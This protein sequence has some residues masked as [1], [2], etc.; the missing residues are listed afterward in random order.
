MIIKIIKGAELSQCLEY[1]AGKG[2]DA[3]FVGGNMASTSIQ[4]IA[5]EFGLVYALAPRLKKNVRHIVVALDEHDPH[6]SLKNALEL[7]KRV[8][9]G[10]KFEQSPWM[11]FQH[12]DGHV[13]HLHIVTTPV[14]YDGGRVPEWN[15]FS[16]AMKLQQQ[17]E[18][19]A[20]LTL[21]PQLRRDDPRLPKLGVYG[22]G[23][24]SDG[25]PKLPPTGK[26]K[27]SHLT[28][29]ERIRIPATRS[30]TPQATTRSLGQNHPGKRDLIKTAMEAL[31]P[32]VGSLGELKL[33]LKAY[34]IDM[35]A[36]L[37][38]GRLKFLFHGSK[39]A[40]FASKISRDY[41]LRALQ[42]RGISLS[43]K[44]AES[45]K[46]LNAPKPYPKP[47]SELPLPGKLHIDAGVLELQPRLG[48][49]TLDPPLGYPPVGRLDMGPARKLAV[50]TKVPSSYLPLVQDLR[51]ALWQREAEAF[52]HRMSLDTILPFL[53]VQCA[54][55][56]E[57][58]PKLKF[59]SPGSFTFELTADDLL[60]RPGM[61]GLRYQVG[62]PSRL[63]MALTIGVKPLHEVP[64][65]GHPRHW[66][67]P[68]TLR[69]LSGTRTTNRPPDPTLPRAGRLGMS[70]SGSTLVSHSRQVQ[71]ALDP[72]KLGPRLEACLDQ[73]SST[74]LP[75][76]GL[77]RLPREVEAPEQPV[78]K[79]G[80]QIRPRSR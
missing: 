53:D 79:L 48:A 38:R 73:R 74:L 10:L 54:G 57:D 14:R 80:Y 72:A 45:Q 61:L 3:V 5:V 30:S 43:A 68:S 55:W 9:R 22:L 7:S 32:S 36:D 42:E 1:V 37:E 70:L 66:N 11:A 49:P 50:I 13:Q 12:H 71:T 25:T 26:V 58:L 64:N 46:S 31:L 16:R 24:H 4:Q 62:R 18:V 78:P 28:P 67:P 21:S 6:M 56:D 8:V 33:G 65:L 77:P 51:H 19:E 75:L 47:H 27:P 2:P 17:L 20:N 23:V 40:I 29:E 52:E 34:G 35:V 60:P 39:G 15:D 59:P 41:T 63:S 69:D 76:P 44:A